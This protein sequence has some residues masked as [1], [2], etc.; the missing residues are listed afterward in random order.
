MEIVENEQ[1]KPIQSIP[2][3]LI[4]N[5]PELFVQILDSNSTH[6]RARLYSNG[7][8]LTWREFIT[9]LQDSASRYVWNHLL[10]T[11]IPFE[12]FLWETPPLSCYTVDNE[13][14]MTCIKAEPKEYKPLHRDTFEAVVKTRD[15]PPTAVAFLAQ[16]PDG[17]PG[18]AQT[19]LISPG[20]VGGRAGLKTY[21]S[22]CTHLGRFVREASPEQHDAFWRVVGEHLAERAESNKPTWV[23][24]EGR[25]VHWLHF[26]LAYRPFHFE[27]ESYR[28]YNHKHYS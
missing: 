13:F 26:R 12:A 7:K 23:S 28:I 22:A 15:S 9:G 14:E 3:F 18:T 6:F 11:S 25:G 8:I 1:E 20:D 24:T 2:S 27:T 4:E 5:L 19:L 10:A 17:T 16:R 21:V